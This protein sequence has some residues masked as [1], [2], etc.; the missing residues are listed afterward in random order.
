MLT[1][2]QTKRLF[3]A[4]ELARRFKV[5]ARTIHRDLKTLD[6]GGIPLMTVDGK[7]Y[8]LMEDYRLLTVMLT[9]QKANAI[10]TVQHLIL[11]NK[12]TSLNAA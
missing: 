11:Y 1:L 2:L 12:D 5:S 9:E 3:T 4:P 8:G 7:G 6:D 10:I